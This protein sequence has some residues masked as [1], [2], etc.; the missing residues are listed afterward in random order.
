MTKSPGSYLGG[1]TVFHV[2]SNWTS[3]EPKLVEKKRIE[4]PSTEQLREREQRKENI[5]KIV[6]RQIRQRS[7]N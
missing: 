6:E 1:S 4:A 2:G 3:K 7:K 5:Q